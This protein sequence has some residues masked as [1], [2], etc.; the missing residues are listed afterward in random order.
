NLPSS[1]PASWKLAA[2]EKRPTPL[3]PSGMVNHI[4]L[5][6][7]DLPHDQLCQELDAIF[8]GPAGG[9]P[10][11]DENE[12]RENSILTGRVLRVTAAVVC[13]DI[14]HKSEGAIALGEW[15]DEQTGRVVPPRPGDEVQ[16]LLRSLEDESGAVVLT[17]RDG[18]AWLEWEDFAASHQE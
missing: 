6:E 9:W 1:H 17:Y 18:R 12:P 4:L 14:G 3:V 13:V 7:Y 11:T 5:R 10:P 8:A 2:T 16:L 15:Y